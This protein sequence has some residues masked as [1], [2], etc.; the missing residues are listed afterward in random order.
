[1]RQI[2][3]EVVA[4]GAEVEVAEVVAAEAEVAARPVT[5]SI[6]VPGAARPPLA[7]RSPG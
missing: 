4:E 6:P 5:P 1:M 7:V 2:I 3:I